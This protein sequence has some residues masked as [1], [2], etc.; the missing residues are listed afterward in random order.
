MVGLLV[1]GGH[2]LHERL[3]TTAVEEVD[4]D[5]LVAALVGGLEVTVEVRHQVDLSAVDHAGGKDTGDLD[6]DVGLGVWGCEYL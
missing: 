1:V 6:A 3:S 5:T 2:V 4:A